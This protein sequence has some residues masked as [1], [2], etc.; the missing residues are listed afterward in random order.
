M[1]HN[2]IRQNDT[3]LT[4]EV[5]N[6]RPIPVIRKITE[7]EIMDNFLQV[8]LDIISIIENEMEKLKEIKKKKMASK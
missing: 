5:K 4:K 1:F 3:K 6:Y 8:K 2:I 7:T